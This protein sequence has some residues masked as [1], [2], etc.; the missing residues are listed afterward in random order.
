M[1]GRFGV[2]TEGLRINTGAHSVV[3]GP[4]AS[5]GP[6]SSRESFHRLAPSAH[7]TPFPL[8]EGPTYIEKHHSSLTAVSGPISIRSTRA[9]ASS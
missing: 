2:I 9:A 3:H 5:M 8:A 1:I 4:C 7:F 6:E